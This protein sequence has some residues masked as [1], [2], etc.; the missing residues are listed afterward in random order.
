MIFSKTSEYALRAL[1]FVAKSGPIEMV[2]VKIVSLETG[3]PPAYVAKIFQGLARAGILQS[4]R[5]MNGGYSFRKHP[6]CVNVLDVVKATDNFSE[7]SL[8]GCVM[9][10]KACSDKSPCSLH[11][12]W[13]QSRDRLVKLMQSTPIADAFK[14]PYKKAFTGIRKGMLSKR[15]R[16]VLRPSMKEVER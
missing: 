16:T 13:A 1:G 12:V 11:P 14:S 10:L 2:G 8:N 3:V 5:G 7:S 4:Q 15:I 6:S 9:G